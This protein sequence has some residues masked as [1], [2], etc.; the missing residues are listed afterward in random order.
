MRGCWARPKKK[1]KKR[2]RAS[3]EERKSDAG[4][5]RERENEEDL[6]GCILRRAPVAADASGE[7]EGA[8]G[9]PTPKRRA[10]G[11]LRDKNPAA[12]QIPQR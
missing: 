10:D 11:L 2:R 9:R 1:K 3:C 6:V 5:N 7:V 12:M 8:G 4:R